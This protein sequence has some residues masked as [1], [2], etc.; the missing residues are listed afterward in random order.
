VEQPHKFAAKY[1]LDCMSDNVIDFP[2]IKEL[3]VVV[4]FENDKVDEAF[5][6]I[7]VAMRGLALAGDVSW[8]HCVDAC[9]MAAAFAARE[10][11]WPAEQLE[12]LFRSIRVQPPE[13]S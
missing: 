9:V 4:D 12:A 3:N 10:D 8:S 6:S 11:D 13:E 5:Y 1:K 7:C 2:E